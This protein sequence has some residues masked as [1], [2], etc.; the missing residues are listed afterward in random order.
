MKN[1]L[2]LS[3]EI[4]RPNDYLSCYG[5]T[6]YHTPN[7]DK[8]AKKGTVFTNFYT[9]APSSAMSFTSMFSGL[10]PFETKRKNF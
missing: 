9:A 2:L 10:N 7:I 8:L 3:K 4:F 1:I 5:S 6:L